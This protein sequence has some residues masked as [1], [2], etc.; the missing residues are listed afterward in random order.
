MATSEMDTTAPGNTNP[1]AVSKK[2]DWILTVN[3]ASLT[4]YEDIK[5]YFTNL[6]TCNYYLCC[7]HIGQENKHYHIFVQFRIPIKPSIKKIHG[8]HI[9]YIR[10]TPQDAV[11]YLRCE[12]DKH[13]KLGITS[14]EIEEI[15]TLRANGGM[16]IKDVKSMTHEEIEE[17]PV[18]YYNIANKIKQEAEN[19]ID[20]D[21]LHKDVKVY[22]IQGPSGVG[23]TNTAIDLVRRNREQ[24]GSKINMLK[25]E[26]GFY[27][28]TSPN[29]KIAIYD[30]FRDSHMKASEFINLI[31]YNKHLLNIKGGSILN[32]Y[33]L[34][35]ITSVQRIDNIY[36]KLVG[37]PRLQ[38]MRRVE[39]INLYNDDATVE[40]ED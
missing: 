36:S 2:R 17:L 32:N 40:E 27:I 4:H 25:Y 26:N 39:I 10:G 12:D 33:Q 37:E 14:V 16:R 11:R 22:W 6:K 34:I 18:S 15:G 1:G 19:E 5:N 28:G 38:W 7:E 23:K 21:D 8:A 35:I 31:D 3:E 29:V 13:K 24:Y 20:I 30:D 9:E